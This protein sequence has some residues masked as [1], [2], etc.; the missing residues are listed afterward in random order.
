MKRLLRKICSLALVFVLSICLASTAYAADTINEDLGLTGPTN[1]F[2]DVCDNLFSQ[3][4]TY[5]ALDSEGNDITENFL[6]KYQS[7]Y[8]TGDYT[9]IW[10]AVKDSA[11]SVTWENETPQ[12]THRLDVNG[13]ASR[14]FYVL[15]TTKDHMPGTTFE[16]SYDVSGTYR[17]HDSTG[18]IFDCSDATLN[19]TAFNGGALFSY[20]LYNISTNYRIASNSKSVTFSAS[21]SLNFI[22]NSYYIPGVSFWQESF[23]PYSGSVTGT[24]Y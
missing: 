13:S 16:M 20:E 21:F 18:E 11:I 14:S 23:G 12:P 10:N 22:Y 3:D 15:G 24:T 9:Q 19:I 6:A 7:A 1:L 17:Y 8:H 5:R 4:S 2:I